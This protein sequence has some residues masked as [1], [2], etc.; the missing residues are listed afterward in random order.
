MICEHWTVDDQLEPKDN[1]GDDCIATPEYFTN[2]KNAPLI[3]GLKHC[4]YIEGETWDEVMTK[5]HQHMGWE[6]Y[7][8]Y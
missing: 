1:L 5:Y 2:P 6:P 8:P 4:C 7:K 3:V